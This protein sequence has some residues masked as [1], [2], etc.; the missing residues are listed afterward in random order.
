MA[1]SS[2]LKRKSYFVDEAAVRRARKALRAS[3]DS[4]A[5]RLSVERVA[6]MEEFWRFMERSR[7]TLAPHSIRKP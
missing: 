2:N 7:R 6:E 1:R 5:V 4:E 3:T